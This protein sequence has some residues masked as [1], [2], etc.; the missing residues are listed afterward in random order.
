MSNNIF[1]A[2]IALSECVAVVLLV[3]IW[4]RRSHLLVKLLSS[5]V[6]IVPVLGPFM[7][8]WATRMPPPQ[9]PALR[10]ERMRGDY[11]Q[12]MISRRRDLDRKNRT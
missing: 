5:F 11:T 10:N 4:R 3:E 9:D 1:L 12:M 6:V 8:F 2:V 7:Y